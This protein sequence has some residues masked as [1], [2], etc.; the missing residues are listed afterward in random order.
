MDGKIEI[1]FDSGVRSGADVIKALALG[2]NM[3]C[4]GRPWLYGL[5]IAGENGVRHV[6][7]AILGEIDVTLHQLGI[8]S[9]KHKDLNAKLLRRVRDTRL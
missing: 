9:V 5:A 1:I 7:K 3:I 6:L 8:P 4:I 2:P